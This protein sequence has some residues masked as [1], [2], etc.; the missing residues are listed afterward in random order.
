MSILNL[1]ESVSEVLPS[2]SLILA[3]LAIDCLWEDC[4]VDTIPKRHIEN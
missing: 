1:I 4:D 3:A 2:Y